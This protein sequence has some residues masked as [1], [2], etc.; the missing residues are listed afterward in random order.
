MNRAPQA[1]ISSKS[2]RVDVFAAAANEEIIV[3]SSILS[4]YWWMMLLRGVISIAF[5]VLIFT[6]PGISLKALTLLFGAF[7]FADGITSLI[8]AFGGRKQNENWWILLLVGL[9]GI[10]IGVLTFI[11]PAMTAIVL[12]FYIAAWAIASGLLEIVAAIRLR[13]EIEGEWWL[14]LGGLLSVAFG[15]F[16][17]A[18]PGAGVLALLWMIGAFAI[19]F[20]VVLIGFSFRA[21]SFLKDAHTPLS[22]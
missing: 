19:A 3:F 17:M 13:R 8:S 6:Q 15:I 14:A 1:D 12:L 22:V 9:C 18:R 16:L 5:G 21:R 7:A 2:R 4:R 20:G 11:S 10:G